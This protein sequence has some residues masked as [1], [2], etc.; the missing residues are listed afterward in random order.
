MCNKFSNIHNNVMYSATG[1]A[2]AKRSLER[3][4]QKHSKTRKNHGLQVKSLC[5][6]LNCGHIN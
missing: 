2:W 3:L 6:K 1:N 4:G 5:L